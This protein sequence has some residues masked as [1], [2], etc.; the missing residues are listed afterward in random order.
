[1]D[2]SMFRKCDKATD[3]FLMHARECRH[4]ISNI[5]MNGAGILHCPSEVRSNFM[6]ARKELDAALAVFN[7]T[8]WPTDEDYDD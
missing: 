3:E 4:L 6:A 7:A 5:A 1:M 2:D 8:T